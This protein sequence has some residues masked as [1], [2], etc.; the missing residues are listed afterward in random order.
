[1]ENYHS[2]YLQ[3]LQP[4]IRVHFSEEL[5]D[6]AVLD[7]LTRL[8]NAHN[9][10]GKV[11]DNC[12]IK[13]RLSRTK[14]IIE[15]DK[16]SEDVLIP[17]Q[18]YSKNEHSVLSPFNKDSS[19]F[20]NGIL[21][22]EWFT[23]YVKEFPFAMIFVCKINGPDT[24][25][26]IVEKISKL[27]TKLWSIDCKLTV[28]L[29]SS[30]DVSESRLSN[31]RQETGL[32]KLNGLVYLRNFEDTL[33]NDCDT[34]VDMVLSHLKDASSAFY[35]NIEHK[36]K[37][38][39]KKFYSYPKVNDVDTSIELTPKFLET[40][41]IIKQGVMLQFIYP[42][43]LE[44]GIK[45]LEIGYQNL[46]TILNST[47]A[48][49]LSQHDNKII[50]QIKDLL[51]VIAFHIV[52]G[53]FS[54][55][56]SLKALK[57]HQ[58]HIL[59]VVSVMNEDSNWISVQYEWLAQLMS[60][61]PYSLIT[62]LNSSSLLKLNTGNVISYYGGL[63]LPEFDVA[64]NPG[65]VYMKAYEKSQFKDKRI[66]LLG[67]AI[68]E[69][70]L[71]QNNAL[72]LSLISGSNNLNSLILYI[73]WLLAEELYTDNKLRASDYYEMAYSSFGGYKW[74]NISHLI[75]EKLL[76]CYS[77]SGNKRMELNVI[78][79][80]ST[81][82]YMSNFDLDKYT[83]KNVF[84]ESL[85]NIDIIDSAVHNLFKVD[86]LLIN[87]E[88]KHEINVHDECILQIDLS[89]NLN[90]NTITSFFPEETKVRIFINQL[91]ISFT[92]ID[93]GLG[94]TGFKN[95]SISND[96]SKKG[97]FINEMSG[98]QLETTFVDSANLEIDI[99]RKVFHHEQKALSSGNFQIDVVKL[100]ITVE[101]KHQDHIINLNKIELHND[102][103]SSTLASFQVDDRRKRN[104]RLDGPSSQIRVYPV[105]P[106][107]RIKPISPIT[108]YIPGERLAIPFQIEYK[109]RHLCKAGQLIASIKSG[110]IA[111]SWD[112]QKDDEPLNLETLEDGSHTLY[113]YTR[114]WNQEFINVELQTVLEQ[115][116]TEN[117]KTIYDT[118][119]VSIPV[120]PNPF[121]VSFVV[122]PTYR[123]RAADMPSPFILPYKSDH[124]MPIA[125]R[126]WEG[127]L[128][129][130]DQYK[131]FMEDAAG[132]K[133]EI[134]SVD[135]QLVSK[136]PELL[137]DLIDTPK[138]YAQQFI[139][140]SKSGF[141][142]RNVEILSSAV[143]KW[144]RKN[145][146]LVVE[147]Q[148][149]E[150][151]IKLPLSEPR[152]LLKVEKVGD[153]YGLQY[154]LE[155]PT[156]RI[157]TFTTELSGF[158]QG[159]NFEQDDRN[160][161]PFRQSAF[162]VLPFSRHHMGYFGRYETDDE[163]TTESLSLIKL[164][165][166]KVFDVQYKVALP[167]IPVTTNILIRDGNLYINK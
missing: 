106:D 85:L 36:I 103:T 133:L 53:Y 2:L 140:K 77:S 31:F 59:N 150:W 125:V 42:H 83:V 161:I 132:E 34:L 30:E 136:N 105:K 112:S 109:N 8:F 123:E 120:L 116:S 99:P 156:P 94:G 126:L 76:H 26:Q 18:E 39:N 27:K 28:I 113:L 129:I 167:T 118:A 32:S 117:E 142:H 51:D 55:E 61:V 41:N 12:I 66:Q 151:E 137:V 146:D 84:D 159:W 60:L 124:N 95:V 119:S 71:N 110:D 33:A 149:P 40:R 58:T 45:L 141:S 9:V 69:L 10:T 104:I 64:T 19:I 91:D 108:C 17:S 1:M 147:F 90:K 48:V 127:K 78:L 37:Q 22:H 165:T 115:E 155:N 21:I 148:T 96:F 74:S 43:N 138:L 46:I 100:Q 139:T 101:I 15:F 13:N 162:P 154:I 54:L 75:L 20:P 86:V 134:V 49:N 14:Y 72:N 89:S 67:S 158:E 152:V 50:A 63:Q 7:R 73:N 145:S 56:D 163:T 16:P 160:V 6:S 121:S 35:S 5:I 52:R 11:W 68:Q 114:E 143:I 144:K 4:F 122:M 47:Y 102:F 3:L 25:H 131:E 88:M 164:P 107:I 29:T 93:S 87:K 166:F 44:P 97:S 65:L 135:F 98:E 128:D 130:F 153:I 80:L 23:K 111:T 62:S 92:R 70:E 82:P 38:R 79:K 24:D 157:F 81:I 57:K